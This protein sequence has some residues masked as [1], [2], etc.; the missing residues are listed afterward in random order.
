MD[1]LNGIIEEGKKYIIKGK[2][3]DWENYC[4]DNWK[5]IFDKMVIEDALET[6]KL[7]SL[8]NLSSQKI[9]EKVDNLS[10]SSIT[11]EELE[12]VVETF[13]LKGKKFVEDINGKSLAKQREKML[14]M[15][16]KRK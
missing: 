4:I 9:M 8:T 14:N 11:W 6:M 13:H 15:I 7:L 2:E 3:K 5:N 12:K 1:V 16:V 10:H